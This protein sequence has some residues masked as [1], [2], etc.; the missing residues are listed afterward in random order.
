MFVSFRVSCEVLFKLFR[1]LLRETINTLFFNLQCAISGYGCCDVRPRFNIYLSL[2]TCLIDELREI[3]KI[4][5]KTITWW[6]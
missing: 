3:E 6:K 5:I 2:S 4:H 1:F